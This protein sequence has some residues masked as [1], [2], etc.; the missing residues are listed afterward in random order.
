MKLNTENYEPINYSGRENPLVENLL[1]NSSLY[2]TQILNADSRTSN[3]SRLEGGHMS[4]TFLVETSESRRVL[5]LYPYDRLA[6]GENYLFDQW[7]KANIPVP[8]ILHSDFTK[9]LVPFSYQMMEFV[10]GSNTEFAGLSE[11]NRHTVLAS[12]AKYLRRAHEIHLDEFGWINFHTDG[13]GDKSWVDTMRNMLSGRGKFLADIGLIDRDRLSLVQQVAEKL[14]Q[15]ERS[16]LLHGDCSLDN[17]LI[18][19]GAVMAFIDPDSIGGDGLY[20]LAYLSASLM[21]ISEENYD[22]YLLETYLGKQP[23]QDEIRKWNVYKI[24]SLIRQVSAS[25]K[26]KSQNANTNTKLTKMMELID[27]LGSV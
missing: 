23:T 13:K 10:S 15:V 6:F 7:N 14:P 5:K 20:D 26:K 12:I 27:S 16:S 3:F 21:D 11:E 25:V 9:L 2:A 8:N 17:I 1:A 19:D 4:T 18:N 24:L 22:S